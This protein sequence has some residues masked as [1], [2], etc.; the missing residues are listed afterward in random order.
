MKTVGKRKP[1][2]GIASAS[3]L[4]KLVAALRGDKP[5]IPKGVYR[6][7]TFEE[8]QKWS[9]EMTTRKSRASQP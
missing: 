8:A 6:F 5:F 4:G 9:L 2:S 7:K 3:A 1:A